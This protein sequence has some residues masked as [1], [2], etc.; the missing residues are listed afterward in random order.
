MSAT[1]PDALPVTHFPPDAYVHVP[2]PGDAAEP[3]R[4]RPDDFQH[5]IT[6]RIDSDR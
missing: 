5:V 2:E 1:P 4:C 3:Y 6:Y